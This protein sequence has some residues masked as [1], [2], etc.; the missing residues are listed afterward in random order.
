MTEQ[1]DAMTEQTDHRISNH[2]TCLQIPIHEMMLN[3]LAL[4]RFNIL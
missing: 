4:L 3:N 2:T 1:T